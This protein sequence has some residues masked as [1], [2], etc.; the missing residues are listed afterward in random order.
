MYMHSFIASI[1][2]NA[3]IAQGLDPYQMPMMYVCNA[4]FIKHETHTVKIMSLVAYAPSSEK[5]QP[6][7]CQSARVQSA[8]QGHP[9]GSFAAPAASHRDWLWA[10]GRVNNGNPFS[11]F[12][13]AGFFEKH[14]RTPTSSLSAIAV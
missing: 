3:S 1:A 9:E 2:S 5:L 4:S 12:R 6:S 8:V 7:I 14:A 13:F 10:A 11:I